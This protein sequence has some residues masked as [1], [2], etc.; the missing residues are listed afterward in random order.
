MGNAS[1]RAPDASIPLP[2]AERLASFVATTSAADL[3]EGVVHKAKCH[4]L[5]TFGAALAGTRSEEASAIRLMLSS[6]ESAGP[7]IA[8]GTSVALSPR[9]AA[10]ANGIAAHAFELDDSG[11]CDHSGAVVLPAAAAA[12]SLA[13]APVT[14]HEFLLAVVLGY[15]IARRVLDACGGYQSHNAAGWHSTG[16]C[17][18]FGAA[19]AAC[20]I[21]RLD[22][23]QCT[24]ALG[25]SGSFAGG[26]WAFIHD[27][28]QAKRIHPGRAAEGGLLAASLARHGITG[29]RVV[30]G[31]GWGGFLPTYAGDRADAE[32]LVRELGRS[33]RITRCAIKPY[34][35]CRGTH[36][37]IDA[38]GRVLGRYRL[39]AG[40]VG[41]VDVRLSP[42]LD[43]M[44]GGRDVRAQPAAQM[45]LPYAVAARIGTWPRRPLGVCVIYSP[46]LFLTRDD[47]TCHPERR[48]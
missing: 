36:S 40:D 8:W 33:W 37:A 15:D 43:G 20:R 14:G 3:P 13:R 22:A 17:G 12:L 38:I 45:S 10:L 41:H 6:E 5:D 29:P 27:G 2:Y 24:T 30:F 47:G 32:A 23:P 31:D 28:S 35:S 18:V 11:G 34:A 16:T 7:A 25:L 39:T 46:G 26:L 44:C 42:F 1:A 48:R 9:S 19:V 21:L 4:V